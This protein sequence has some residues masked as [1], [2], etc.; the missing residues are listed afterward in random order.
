MSDLYLCANLEEKWVV[1]KGRFLGVLICNHS[2]RTVQSL[3]SQVVAPKAERDDNSLDLLLVN[4][5][6]R[7]QLLRFFG[8]LQFGWHLSLP[9]VE[10]VK[11]K[12]VKVRSGINTHNGCDIDG[13]LL[14][15][16]GQVL[17]SLL[18]KQCR[19]I[20]RPARDCL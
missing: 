20:G 11:V 2:C 16:K 13:E 14:C 12:A 10:Y 15:V 5:S 9:C 17:C 6:G 1:K 3:S 18:P 19:L 4:G 7:M 8:C